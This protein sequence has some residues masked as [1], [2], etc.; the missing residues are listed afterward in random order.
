LRY[1]HGTSTLGIHYTRSE[2]QYIP[3]DVN[4]IPIPQGY[5]SSHNPGSAAL[6]ITGNFDA[7]FA[8]DTD[9]RRSITGYVFYLANAPITWQC[10]AQ[11]TVALSTMESEY[12]AL[13][14]ATQ[15]SLWL[16]MMIEEL[17]S[18]VLSP[19]ILHEDNKAC[20]MFADH[21]GHFS[22]TKHID[23]RYHF[24]RER[25]HK[26]DIRVDYIKTDRQVADIFTKA[27]NW[28]KFQDFRS[29][30]L[31]PKHELQL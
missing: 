29:K 16:K 17:G 3:L 8:N 18:S 5:L 21:S 10:K 15:E 25:V 7:D 9:D 14:S 1:L 22:R 23:Y 6:H 30:L 26:G 11:P 2:N 20:Q 13:A 27:L 4:G 19:I 24:V 12:M 28:N 31:Q